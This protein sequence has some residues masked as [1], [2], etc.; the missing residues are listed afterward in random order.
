MKIFRQKTTLPFIFVLVIL[1]PFILIPKENSLLFINRFH[2]SFLDFLFLKITWLGEGFLIFSALIL[3]IFKRIKWLLIFAIGLTLH[4]LLIQINKLVFFTDV[5][6]PLG[7][8]ISIGK[9]H[10]LYTIDGL[11]IH[12][13]DSFPSGHTTGAT[14]A[15][16]FIALAIKNKKLSWFMALLSLSV[17]FSRVYLVQHFVID[18]YFGFLFGAV[19]AILGLIIVKYIQHKYLWMNH[20]I[21][22]LIIPKFK[23]KKAINK[24]WKSNPKY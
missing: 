20:F 6:R 21:L 22:R 10:L 5:V 24:L 15:A 2:S 19:S 7:Y 1:F 17:A 13:T 18:V 14:F 8:F 23:R 16:T 4:L 3:I 12:K 9:E 11:K